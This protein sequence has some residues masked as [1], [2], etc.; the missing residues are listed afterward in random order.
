MRNVLFF[1]VFSLLLFTSCKKKTGPPATRP[2]LMT[3]DVAGSYFNQTLGGVIFISDRQGKVLADT[4]CLADGVYKFFGQDGTSAPSLMEVTIVKSE[5]YWHSFAITLETYTCI[6]PS[7]WKLQGYRATLAGQVTPVYK[8]IPAHSD[9]ILVSSSGYSNLAFNLSIPIDLYK[10]T[11]DIYFGIPTSSGMKYK[12]FSGIQVNTSDTF[13]L[14]NSQVPDHKTI[15][16][17]SPVEYYE[18]RIQGF[19]DGNVNSP[20]PYLLDE[21][22]GN[23]ITANSVDVYYPP[24][25]FLAFHSDISAVESYSTNQTWYYHTDG[26]IPAA[27]K[28]IQAGIVS[29]SSASAILNV[30]ISG[31]PDAT[32]G[33]WQFQNPY[34][35]LVNWTVFGPDTA[36]SLQLPQV[37]PSLTNMFPW[38]SRDSLAFAHVRLIDLINSQGYPQ[39]INLLFNPANPSDFDRQETT[40]LEQVPGSKKLSK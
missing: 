19:P 29:F 18:C 3:M 11:D 26:G 13:D 23:G 2:L 40:M 36:T 35:G 5:P 27:F 16:F 22:L 4:F 32:S 17:P 8:N 25:K 1:L 30:K 10:N 21:I 20:I 14:S 38:F 39:M 31:S 9:A 33:T 15:S 37:A 28:K 34:K 12:W 7:K 24:A 6:Q